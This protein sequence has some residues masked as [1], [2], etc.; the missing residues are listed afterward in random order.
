MADEAWNF[1]CTSLLK[2]TCFITIH[3]IIKVMSVERNWMSIE[4]MLYD[5]RSNNALF[6]CMRLVFKPIC[7]LIIHPTPKF[8]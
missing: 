1:N 3:Y 8:T 4:S 2:Q 6:F 7:V 5:G